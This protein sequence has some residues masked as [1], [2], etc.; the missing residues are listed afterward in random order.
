MCVEL[1]VAQIVQIKKG[2]F[3]ICIVILY[4]RGFQT[5]FATR[6]CQKF[7]KILQQ[8]EYF[9]FVIDIKEIIP[10]L[11]LYKILILANLYCILRPS[12]WLWPP[13]SLWEPLP[14]TILSFSVL[15]CLSFTVFLCSCFVCFLSLSLFLYRSLSVFLFLSFFLCLSLF[16]LCPDVAVCFHLPLVWLWV[17]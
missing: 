4:R 5:F 15:F 12:K 9:C 1:Y 13:A 14:F 2:N 17:R 6:P 16:L 3:S 8:L 7:W 11:I 10:I